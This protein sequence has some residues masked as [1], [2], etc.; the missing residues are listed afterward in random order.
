M[1][2]LKL[3]WKIQR[4]PLQFEP[5]TL[6]D[7]TNVPAWEKAPPQLIYFQGLNHELVQLVFLISYQIHQRQQ[8]KPKIATCIIQWELLKTNGMNK[9]YK[10]IVR[11]GLMGRIKGKFKPHWVKKRFILILYSH[12]QLNHDLCCVHSSSSSTWPQAQMTS[13]FILAAPR[14][15]PLG[16]L[17]VPIGLGLEQKA[18]RVT[19]EHFH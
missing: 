15:S 9:S 12:L 11:R 16:T 1:I 4:V 10:H 18:D 5:I 17:D 14:C 8:Q 7:S 13:W 6:L 3:D 2:V 19:R